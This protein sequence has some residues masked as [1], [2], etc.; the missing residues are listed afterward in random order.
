MSSPEQQPR[1]RY[2]RRRFVRSIM[3][4]AG[5]AVAALATRTQII[6]RENLPPKGPLILV[7]NHIAVIEVGMMGVYTP[8]ELEIMA[9]GD[10][11]LDPRYSWIADLWGIIPIKRGS[12]DRDGMNK[13]LDVLNQGGVV[14]LFPEGGIWE[15]KLRQARQ[16]VAWLSNK[17]QAPVV[18]IGFGGIEGAL[19]QIGR[20]RRPN[21]TM[22]IG[23]V[24]PPVKVDVPGRSRKE[25]LQEGA[26][27][28]MDRIKELIPEDERRIRTQSY[29][30]ETFDFH[31][32]LTSPGGV[33]I[34]IPNDVNIVDKHGLSK[35][36]HRPVMMDVF[37]RNLK[38]PVKPLVRLRRAHPAADIAASARSVLDWLKDN[39]Y[40]FHYRFGHE[41]GEAMM[42]GLRQLEQ[43]AQW[44]GEHYP[45]AQLRLKPI[46]RYILIDTNEEV[47]EEAPPEMQEM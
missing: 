4:L 40:F 22:N 33:Q 14:G 37:N 8:Y 42:N 11:P 45:D 20:F 18:P 21:L 6:G 13:A 12:M 38:L 39:P 5:R 9:A 43:G 19:A 29:I 32:E 24:I 31:W 17:A 35:L 34:P 16:G 10:I 46:R 36:F 44:L 3:R 23:K 28:I 30:G 27:Y 25:L 15:T 1:L 47:V 26:D 2:P 41:E 7:G